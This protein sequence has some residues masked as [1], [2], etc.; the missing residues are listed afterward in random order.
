MARTAKK[1]GAL[2]S[3][4]VSSVLSSSVALAPARAVAADP[5][6]GESA[7]PARP[8]PPPGDVVA[9][10]EAAEAA[11][12]PVTPPPPPPPPPPMAGPVFD[13]KIAV[14]A[15]LRTGFRFENPSD[16][17]KLNDILMDQIYLVIAARGQFTPW[18]KWQASLAATHYTPPGSVTL[19]A[20]LQYPNA[21]L[22]DLIIK[23]EPDD[24]FN[25]WAGKMIV[26]VDRANLSG[27]WFTN[28]WLMRGS[29]PRREALTPAPYGIKSGP[30]G[31]DQG[32]SVWGQFLGGRLKYYGGVFALDNQSMDAHPMFVGRAVVNFLDPEPGYYNQS[33][34]HGEKDI[35]AI[36]GGYQY[37]KGGSVLVIPAANPA[38]EVGDLKVLALD[39]LVDKKLGNHVVTLDGNAYLADD[40][41]PLKRLFLVGV[42]YVSPL[43]GPGRIAPAARLQIGTV[44]Q[45]WDPVAMTGI[46]EVGLD[47]EFMQVDGYV[48]YLVKSHFAKILV[49]GFYTKTSY[50][51]G[52][53]GFVAKGVQIGLQLIAL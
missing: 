23:F 34:Y 45:V 50:K 21:G 32:V 47:R 4:M 25:V 8:T 26:P 3:L 1:Y 2:V 46:R 6:A 16:A 27:P 33:A 35:I 19:D 43:V 10:T 40:F 7:G 20:E 24:A 31:R 44:P 30:F 12:N 17:G 39:L 14:G 28:Y 37:Q 42:G 48:Q 11:S 13:P 49:G 38:L 51:S 9:P 36:G 15:W 41:Q 29:F 18:L 22:Q 53:P 52:A 5:E